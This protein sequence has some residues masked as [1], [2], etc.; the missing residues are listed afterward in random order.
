MDAAWAM[1][2]DADAVVVAGSSLTVFSGFR[3]VRRA[4]REGK[5]IV[6]LN[7]GETRGDELATALHRERLGQ[8]LPELVELLV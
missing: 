6:I 3:F 8:S 4:H 2:E 5:P 1:Y 7:Q